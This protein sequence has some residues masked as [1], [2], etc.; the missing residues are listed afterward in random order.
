MSHND[1]TFT[2]YIEESQKID[3]SS[4]VLNSYIYGETTLQERL[5]LAPCNTGNNKVIIRKQLQDIDKIMSP[6][7][8]IVPHQRKIVPPNAPRLQLY[9]SFDKEIY[10][11]WASGK[12]GLSNHSET[13]NLIAIPTV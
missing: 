3:Q 10:P 7:T 4:H 6:I 8:P 2:K 5:L 11:N 13:R 1:C 12:Y 9:H